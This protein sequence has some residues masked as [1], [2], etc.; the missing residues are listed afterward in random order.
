M[1]TWK[2]AVF[3]SLA[4]AGSAGVY[5]TAR[6]H[7]QRYSP[8]CDQLPGVCVYGNKDPQSASVS[9]HRRQDGAVIRTLEVCDSGCSALSATYK[10]ENARL[11]QA[12]SF[13]QD[14]SCSVDAPVQVALSPR[15]TLVPR[16]C[17]G[18]S[19]LPGSVGE[20][21]RKFSD[22]YNRRGSERYLAPYI[23]LKEIFISPRPI[24]LR[25]AEAPPP[26][27]STLC[28]DGNRRMI[29]AEELACGTERRLSEIEPGERGF[30]LCRVRQARRDLAQ[31]MGDSS[32]QVLSGRRLRDEVF[33]ADLTLRDIEGHEPQSPQSGFSRA[34][35]LLF[36][37]AFIAAIALAIRKALKKAKPS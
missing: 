31:A 9:I 27:P 30:A 13:G 23:G 18:G 5:G 15:G 14:E 10:D 8:Q 3:V 32:V 33:R 16:G 20:L 35:D 21:G 1:K 37:A 25:C 4:L 11:P 24:E 19:V 12:I 28:S 22:V 26:Q 7:L 2:K 36:G 34:W 17:Y 29:E 6:F